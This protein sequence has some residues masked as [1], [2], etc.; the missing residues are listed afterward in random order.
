VSVT[1]F[2]LHVDIR[3]FGKFENAAKKVP[4]R[5]GI[6][7]RLDEFKKKLVDMVGE[8]NATLPEVEDAI[9]CHNHEDFQGQMG[10][11]RCPECNPDDVSTW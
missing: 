4:T 10:A 1:I 5:I 8:V 2:F 11:L 7:L 3:K 6:S 9:P